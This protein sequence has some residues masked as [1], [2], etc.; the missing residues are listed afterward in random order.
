MKPI[1]DYIKY[2]YVQL[3]GG[4]SQE[5]LLYLN[6]FYAE[7]SQYRDSIKRNVLEFESLISQKVYNQ[8]VN[9]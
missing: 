8:S 2:R 9:K 7:R 6:K 4:V 5:H 3:K 1:H